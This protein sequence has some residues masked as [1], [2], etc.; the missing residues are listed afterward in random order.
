MK[1][2]LLSLIFGGLLATT[3]SAAPIALSFVGIADAGPTVTGIV[4]GATSVQVT[5]TTFSL[6]C[7]G[8]SAGL[9][10]PTASFTSGP[11]FSGTTQ[12]TFQLGA[13]VGNL[14]YTTDANGWTVQNLGSGFFGIK[15]IGTFTSNI[16]GVDSQRGFL[17][18]SFQNVQN[19]VSNF[20]GSGG[21]VPE[22]GSMALLGSGLLGL[23]FI[24]RRRARR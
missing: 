12:E 14:V 7:L 1:K 11:T 4:G 17:D 16:A 23:G 21:T 6:L 3:A 20:S 9:C 8:G 19:G 15:T 24:A 10:N 22:P 13:A 18:I 5:S 2:V